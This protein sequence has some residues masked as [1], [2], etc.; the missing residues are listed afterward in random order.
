MNATVPQ[1]GNHSLNAA[2]RRS[3]PRIAGVDEA[4]RGPLAGPVV[5]AAVILDPARPIDGLGDSKALSEPRRLAL[6]ALI[7]ERAWVGVGI[8]EPAEIDRL[9]ILHATMAAMARAVGRLAVSPALVRVD[10]NRVPPG[11]PCPAEAII[12]G[13]ATDA[14]IGAAS[15]IAKTIRDALMT[16]A[17]QRF[18][19]YGLAGHKG[20]P[21]PAHRA[22]LNE[23]GATPIHRRSYAPVRA[24]LE[25]RFSTDANRC[26]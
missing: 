21:S 20:Y 25:S 5:A 24:A 7:R 9:N 8:A 22:A 15:I 1:K 2:A 6:Y 12:K 13:D 26:G 3:S 17:A 14:S 4:G 18:P 23:L 11:L 16:N 19:G 10:G